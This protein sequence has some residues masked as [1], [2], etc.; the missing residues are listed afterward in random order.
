[1]RTNIKVL[2]KN[3]KLVP[4]ENNKHFPSVKLNLEFAKHGRI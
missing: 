2:T 1:M 3:Q 4:S